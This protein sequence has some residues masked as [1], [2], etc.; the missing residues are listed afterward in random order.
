M[1][2]TEIRTNQVKD[3]GL[4][5]EDIASNANISLSKLDSSTIF[6]PTTDYQVATKKYVDDNAGG[7][8]DPSLPTTAG[9]WRDDFVSQSTETGE[10]GG[11][12]WTFTN[13]SIQA[14]N[15]EQNHPGIQTRR[16][17]TTANQVAS[18]YLGNAVDTTVF[19]YDEF[20]TMYFVFSLVSI[21]S[22]SLRI[23]L[24]NNASSNP[25]INGTYLEFLAATDSEFFAVSR[26]SSTETRRSLGT[27]N[28]NWHTLKIQRVDASTVR[29]S[30]DG[31]S[32][33]DITTNIVGGSTNLNIGVQVIPTTTTAKDL[34]MDFFSL[35]SLGVTR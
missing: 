8:S 19:R 20:D 24:F 34:K 6:N 18:L 9:V 15:N 33:Q 21:A 26:A 23:G 16:S 22:V 29:F 32:S 2:I 4:L 25:P 11:L 14:A 10:V 27:A 17:G 12:N 3:G 5:N 35:K 28:T 1:S 13:G 7:G 31:G 30:L